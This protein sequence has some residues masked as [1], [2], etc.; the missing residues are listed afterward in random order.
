MSKTSQRTDDVTELRIAT[1]ATEERVTALEGM[2]EAEQVAAASRYTELKNKLETAANFIILLTDQ[3]TSL[4]KA[5]ALDEAKSC[6]AAVK[7][8]ASSVTLQ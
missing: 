7:L 3:V 5:A 8:E 1:A 6:I 4:Q 2:L